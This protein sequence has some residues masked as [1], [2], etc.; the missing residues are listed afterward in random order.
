MSGQV[1]PLPASHLYHL[2]SVYS[3]SSIMG[4]FLTIFGENIMEDLCG[5]SMLPVK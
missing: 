2:Q 1:E 3:L 4:R 5:Q